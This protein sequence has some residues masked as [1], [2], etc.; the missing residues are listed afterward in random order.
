MGNPAIEDLLPKAGW[1][2]Y[3]L[4]RMASKRAMELADGS[5]KLI[6]NYFSHK[7]TTI[8][9]EEIA[10]GKVVL[11]EVAQKLDIHLKKEDVTEG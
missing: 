6:A 7:T 3:K 10:A 9:L 2:I 4:V 5:P 11:K 8:A 1:S